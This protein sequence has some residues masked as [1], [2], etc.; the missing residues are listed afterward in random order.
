MRVNRL[1]VLAALGGAAV[2]SVVAQQKPANV[3]QL[4]FQTPKF[5]M[6]QQYEAGRKTK[7]E[8]H[9]KQNDPRPLFVW[10]IQTGE[11]TGTFV[12]G[13]PATQWKDLDNPPITEEADQAEWDKTIGSST[14]SL[15]THFYTQMPDIS[16]PSAGNMPPKYLEV[17]TF[18]VHM[19][20]SD[21]WVAG[22]K[23]ITAAINKTNWPVHYSAFSLSYGG[24]GNTFVLA[25]EHANY[26]DFEE[27]EKPFDKMLAEAMGKPAA[28]EL[29]KHLDDITDS[30]EAQ[31]I[32][33]RP[34]LSYIPAAMMK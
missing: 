25:I 14:Q 15:V 22:M 4:E 27:P 18:Q 12:V 29:M 28:T 21:D 11:Q 20:K 7:A 34:D 19:G 6:T 16:R 8:W 13:E 17:V 33:F 10:E 1:L 32:K 26:A 31:I 3:L 30:T 2:I 5:G 23:K 24:K 9:K